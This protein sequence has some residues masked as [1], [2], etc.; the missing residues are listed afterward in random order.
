MAR[1]Y[2]YRQDPDYHLR[3]LLHI[4]TPSQ[5]E[6]LSH[7]GPGLTIECCTGAR[8]CPSLGSGFFLNFNSIC[9]RA[10]VRGRECLLLFSVL[11]IS[12]GSTEWREVSFAPQLFSCHTP[13]PSLIVFNQQFLQPHAF[14]TL[15]SLDTGRQQL[16]MALR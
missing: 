10:N 12:S 9:V 1:R 3:V 5:S 16:S 7:S 14:C 8:A 15:F 13:D 4:M 11:Y 2:Y 6:C